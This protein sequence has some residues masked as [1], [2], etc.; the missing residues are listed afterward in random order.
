LIV[1][2]DCS[3]RKMRIDSIARA[4]Q[5]NDAPQYSHLKGLQSRHPRVVTLALPFLGRP[6]IMQQPLPNRKHLLS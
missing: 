4:A 5:N 3:F 1:Q 2:V 6:T